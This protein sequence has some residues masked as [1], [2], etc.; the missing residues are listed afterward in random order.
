M[1]LAVHTGHQD[2]SDRCRLAVLVASCSNRSPD[3]HETT[4]M[5]AR[6][7]AT[8]L[9][10]ALAAGAALAQ[11][12]IS[13]RQQ[14]VG[15]W[16]FVIAEITYADGRKDLPFGDK[17]KGMLIFTPDGHFSQVHVSS[18][19]PRIAS[20]NRLAGTPEDNRAIV[21]GTLALFGS[22]TV[23]EEKKTVTFHITASTY[24]NLEGVSQTRSIDQL[25][26]T[27]FRNTNRAASRGVP[28]V[29]ANL[30]RRAN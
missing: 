5:M 23:D 10:M 15:T 12:E 29:A 19:L 28:A 24:P 25:T 18:G 17:P 3:P 20:D 4:T 11:T 21:H 8:M 7:V 14:I 13:L 6:L 1:L 22:Y 2:E 27:E 16:D 9:T 30:Y 26:A